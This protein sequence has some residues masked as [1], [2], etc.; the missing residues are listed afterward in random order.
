MNEENQFIRVAIAIRDVLLNSFYEAVKP[1]SFEYKV[2]SNETII[3]YVELDGTP[4]NIAY[5]SLANAC[6]INKRTIS[7]RS[8][9]PLG[10]ASR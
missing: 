4:P 8:F 10:K 6:P 3:K 7:D 2:E 1:Q 5:A 9:N